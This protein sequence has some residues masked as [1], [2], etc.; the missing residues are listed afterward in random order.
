MPGIVW[1]EVESPDPERFMEFHG[2]LWRWT[3]AP[4]FEGRI[5]ADYW[6][7]ESDGRGIGGLQRSAEGSAEPS[8]GTRV[9]LQVADLESALG[10]VV[11]AGGVVE[12]HRTALGGDDRW[13]ATFRDPTGVS[14]GLWTANDAR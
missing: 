8:A 6:I 14:F 5:G 2:V 13:Y 7:V 9:Y 10:A 11:R 3:F 12:R 4:A 1:W